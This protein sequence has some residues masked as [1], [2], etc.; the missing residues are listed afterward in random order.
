MAKTQ[1]KKARFNLESPNAIKS[2]CRLNNLSGWFATE[3]ES[4]NDPVIRKVVLDVATNLDGFVR[5]PPKALLLWP[6]C[7]RLTKYHKYP[8]VIRDVA[9]VSRVKGLDSRVNGPAIAAFRIAGGLRPQRYG[10]T[11]SWSAH[12]VYSGKFPYIGR[13]TTLHAAKSGL[14]FTQ[15]AGLVAIHPI[16]DQMCDEFPAF[17][18]LLR[19]LAFT[20][21]CYDPDG[22][23][24]NGSPDQYGFVGKPCILIPQE[25]INGEKAK[26][27]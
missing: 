11:N 10:S 25:A 1:A 12:H 19:A 24:S 4:V 16:A 21:F 27:T 13:E 9:T 3:I 7:D 15:S 17:A 20:K 6:G 23:F 2:P 8:K 5:W 14:H 26:A 22:V 18:W